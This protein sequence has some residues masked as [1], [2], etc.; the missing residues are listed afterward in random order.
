MDE[1]TTNRMPDDSDETR[2]APPAADDATQVMRGEATDATRVMPAAGGAPP[3]PP[4][5][6]PT[7]LMTHQ[8]SSSSG[9]G[10]PWWVWLVVVLVIV[11][12]VAAVWFFYLRPTDAA[13]GD[14]FIGNWA[15]EA[16]TGG[17]LVIKTSGEQFKITQYDDELKAVGSTVADLVD[18]TLE[19]SVQASDLGITGATGKVDGTL[20]HETSGDRLKL[21][22]SSGSLK[23]E[24][25]VF[26]RVDVL[27]PATPEPTPT[28]TPSPTPTLS[29]SP[30][31][32]PTTTGSPS[33]S[34]DQQVID[35]IAKIQ[36]GIVTWA[37]NNNNLYPAPQDV[38]SGG[39]I[40]EYVDPWPTN[41]FT[42]GP[43]S[44]GTGPGGYVYEQLNGGQ[45][46]KLTGYLSS[47][48]TYSVP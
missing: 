7:L 28:P 37:T 11:A 9:S 23:S 13:T 2:V 15:P 5:V 18:D 30:T 3:P 4:P 33:P 19:I 34:A 10:M 41:P 16:M 29:P 24:V 45:G 46:Y 22:F 43:M 1:D 25:I 48:L 31:A 14:E 32:S 26:V 20:T 36:I 17:G 8:K 21:Q 6:R 44:P 39:G 47:G 27:L 38:V 12:A 42:S 35:G 40:S